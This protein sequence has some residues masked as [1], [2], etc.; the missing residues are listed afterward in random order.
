M[1]FLQRLLGARPKPKAGP[2]DAEFLGD[3]LVF[4]LLEHR[5]GLK[6]DDFTRDLPLTVRE[7]AHVWV[8][9]YLAWVYRMLASAKHGLEF[10]TRMV[11]SAK[12]RLAAGEQP[13]EFKEFTGNLATAIDFWFGRLDEAAKTIGT[14]V[15]TADGGSVEPPLEWFAAMSFLALDA[16]SPYHGRTEFPDRIDVNLGIALSAAKDAALS[17]IEGAV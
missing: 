4:E 7:V 15:P 9:L 17:F 11:S 13:K 16:S 3:L 2:P 14:K 6:L 12:A 8:L 1:S 10:S 5:F